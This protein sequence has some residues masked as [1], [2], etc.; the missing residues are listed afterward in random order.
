MR[1]LIVLFLFTVPAFAEERTHTVVP[2]DYAS[3]SAITE[4]AVSPDGKH[5]AYALAVWGKAEDNRRS[6]V[7]I[8]PTDGKGK[9]TKLTFARSFANS[10]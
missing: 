7:W 10:S 8:V 4:I 2:A 5:V 1:S 3:I 9:P 6:D